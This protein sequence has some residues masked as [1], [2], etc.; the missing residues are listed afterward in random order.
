MKLEDIVKIHDATPKEDENDVHSPVVITSE[1]VTKE[2]DMSLRD[3]LATLMKY[4]KMLEEE[5][6]KKEEN[7][8][9]DKTGH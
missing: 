8:V 3:A 4:A 1:N 9:S 6:K 5:A 7:E 2:P